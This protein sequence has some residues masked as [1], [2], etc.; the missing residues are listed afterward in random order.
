MVYKLI[1][2]LLTKEVLNVQERLKHRVHNF[3]FKLLS[4]ETLRDY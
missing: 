1:Q 2:Q 3:L 4:E